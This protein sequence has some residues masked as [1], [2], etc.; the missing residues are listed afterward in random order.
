MSELPQRPPIASSPISVIL[1]AQSL[2]TETSTPGTLASISRYPPPALR[3]SSDPG[4]TPRSRARCRR[5]ASTDISLRP[6]PRLPRRL[7]RRHRRRAASA[8]GVLHLRQAIS[9]G[10]SGSIAQG[11]RQGRSR[12][13]L[14]H[15]PTGTAV[16][17]LA[18]HR[19][20]PVQ[21]CRARHSAASSRLLA[22]LR[23]LGPAGSHAGS[24]ACRCSMRN[25]RSVWLAAR[26]F[27]GCRSSRAARL[28]A[29]AGRRRAMCLLAEEPVAW[30]PPT[31]P[32]SDAISFGQDARLVFRAPDFGAPRIA[33][34]ANIPALHSGR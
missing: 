5:N 21:P 10:R 34:A 2:S 8:P 32:T 1:F 7:Q 27:N 12:R 24:S 30:T 16:A 17:R 26:C 18:G 33:P 23:G 9:A 19:R 15:R 25:A 14:S 11:D 6:L 13:R 31:L 29:T 4:N 3:N 22:R 20:R 28:K